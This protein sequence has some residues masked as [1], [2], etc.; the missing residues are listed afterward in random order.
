MKTF[1]ALE[2]S[3]AAATAEVAEFKALLD[4]KP[5]LSEKSDVLPFFR[6]RRHL[7]L[8]AGSLLPNISRLGRLAWEYD[9]FGDFACDLAVGDARANAYALIE[10]ED[11]RA[12]SIFQAGAK[13][14]DEWGRR[15]E[16]GF[17]QLVDWFWK[18]EDQSRTEEFRHRFG[19]AD[20]RFA[21]MLVVGRS[22]FLP[23]RER[24]RLTWRLDRVIINSNK[25]HCLTFDDLYE[26]LAEKLE[27]M[28][29]LA[30]GA[31]AHGA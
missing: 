16:H 1:D 19:G 4:A 23:P 12:N 7:S 3:Y 26:G 15:F 18:L 28:G 5:E 17:S 24:R 20:A 8:L 21:A 11:A 30:K 9:L 31:P 25:I 29:L 2:F 6:Q 10:F 22:G 13:Y 27:A 14:T